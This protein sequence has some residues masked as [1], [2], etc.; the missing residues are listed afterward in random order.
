MYCVYVKKSS[1]ISRFF[2]MTSLHRK[3][4]KL[5]RINYFPPG[6][7]TK[8]LLRRHD[9]LVHPPLKWPQA[10]RL[11]RSVFRSATNWLIYQ[12]S[13]SP[14]P[15]LPSISLPSSFIH[16]P[17][18][19]RLSRDP[20]PNPPPSCQGPSPPPHSKRPNYI[21]MKLLLL[22]SFLKQCFSVRTPGRVRAWLTAH[23]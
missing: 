18:R 12:C 22:L 7:M 9:L 19:T 16:L 13:R 2:E 5:S 17:N 21:V 6:E 23:P 15:S 10:A 11:G 14:H 3:G 4:L 1:S 8:F 20:Q